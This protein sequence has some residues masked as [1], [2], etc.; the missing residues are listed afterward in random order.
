P[1]VVLVCKMI[2]LYDRD[3]NLLRKTTLDEVPAIFQVSTLFSLLILLLEGVF[4]QG[5]LG[6]GELLVLWGLLFVFMTLGRTA[7][8]RIVQEV[9]PTERCLVIGDARAAKAIERNFKMTP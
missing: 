4:V 6:H 8:R 7:A 5:H 2:G 9:L 3:E 1:L